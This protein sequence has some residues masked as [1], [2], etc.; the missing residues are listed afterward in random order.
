VWGAILAVSLQARSIDLTHDD[1]RAFSAL[2]AS[3]AALAT[4]AQL[5]VGAAS[6]RNRA[7]RARWY[8]AGAALAVPALVWFYA[9]PTFAQLSA[10]FLCL[11]VAMNAAIA[12]Y[13]AV[14]PDYI[15]LERRGGAS[16]W[17]S[18]YQSLG[19]AAGVLIAGLVADVR[20]V[21][22]S[23]CAGLAATCLVTVA[24]VRG[25]ALQAESARA[26]V[27]LN[28]PLGTL[29]LSRGLIYVGF[30]TLLDY[31]EFFVR[32]TLGITVPAAT[33]EQT[34]FLFLTFTLAAIPGAALGGP[35]AD[36][37]DKRLVVTIACATLVCALALL[38]GAHGLPAAYAAAGFAGLAWGGFVAADWALAT[39]L[40]PRGA[41]ATAMA[42]W[43]VAITA[44][45]VAAPLLA[46]P[47]IERF[48][49]TALGLGPRVAILT[50]MAEFALGGLCVWR[51][52]RA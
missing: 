19:N 10:A 42:V 16:A 39:A 17:M 46:L 34:G 12:P 48:N 36:R 37:Y 5:V 35:P 20:V 38:A 26:T 9:A 15:A 14:I 8:F 22:S 28:G 52:P 27:R 41:M 45:Q 1:V 30:F 49:A 18:A 33:H 50:A 4:V 11:Q 24:H 25:L 51:L 7:T 47:L 2:A 23:L 6:D 3:G 32:D 43:N 44:P 31:L 13:Q 29:L 21:A 40:L